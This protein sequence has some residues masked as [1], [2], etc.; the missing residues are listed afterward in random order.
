MDV[1]EGS[2]I[3]W[4]TV[5]TV[6][7]LFEIFLK[8]DLHYSCTICFFVQLVLSGT[9]LLHPCTFVV[10]FRTFVGIFLDI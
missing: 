4:Y 10:H 8:I 3:C 6:E 7:E 1:V 9:F 2:E 5:P